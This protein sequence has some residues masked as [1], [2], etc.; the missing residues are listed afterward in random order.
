MQTLDHK[1]RQSPFALV[2]MFFRIFRVVISQVWPILIP[3]LFKGK[4]NNAI[5]WILIGGGIVLFVLIRTVLDYLY[6]TFHITGGQLIVRKGFF[7]K[8]NISIP[9][10]RIQAVHL[11][12]SILHTL[13]RTYKVLIDTAGTEKEEVKIYALSNVAAISFREIILRE[14]I[15]LPEKEGVEQQVSLVSAKQISKLGTVDLLKL[16]LSANHLET[17]GVIGVFIVGRYE[18]IKPL[19]IRV[20][21]LKHLQEYGDTLQFTWTVISTLIITVLLITLLISVLRTFLKFYGYT[22]QMDKKGFHIRWGLLQIKQKMIPFSKVQIVKWRSNFLRRLIGLGLLNLKVAGD[23]EEKAKMRIEIPTSSPEQV[24]AIIHAYQPILPSIL[25]PEG[26]KMHISYITRRAFF[27]TL[28]VLLVLCGLLSFKFGWDAT[29]VLLWWPWSLLRNWWFWRNFRF[30]VSESG[31]QRYASTFGMDQELLNWKHVQY[32]QLRQTLYQKRKGLAT[33][34]LHTAGGKFTLPY[35]QYTDGL[36]ISNY[37]L[38]CT[39][40]TQ[41]NWM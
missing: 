27:V 11:E 15:N 6:F 33:L 40:S 5:M 34:F 29:W 41:Q 13:T 17:M 12:Q 38:F 32:V 30:W 23:K 22:V 24:T 1:Q 7:T 36:R 18:D 37:A 14:S 26:N 4:N 2:I 28:P 19:F 9:L 35:I 10:E 8:K 16:S 20:S 3:L 39:E 21:F 31:V 25:N